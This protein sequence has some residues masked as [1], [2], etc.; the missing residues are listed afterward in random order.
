MILRFQY[1]RFK[2]NWTLQ[3][4]LSKYKASVRAINS[5][6]EGEC[7]LTKKDLQDLSL[8]TFNVYELFDTESLGCNGWSQ[9]VEK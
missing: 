1:D 2:D 7:L 6:F 3:D 9:I 8:D 4:C 5:D